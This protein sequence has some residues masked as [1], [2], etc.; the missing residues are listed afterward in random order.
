MTTAAPSRAAATAWFA[1][2]PPGSIRIDGPST[3]SPA[4]GMRG[5]GKIRSR[6]IEPNTM[7]MSLSK[8]GGKARQSFRG[9]GHC[10]TSYAR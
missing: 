8:L 4:T 2:L 5:T 3:V 6:L 7:I 1:P 9:A 10:A